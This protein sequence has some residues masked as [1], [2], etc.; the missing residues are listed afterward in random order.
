VVSADKADG[1]GNETRLY[2][3]L[4]MSIIYA[5]GNRNPTSE[6]N[7]Y[8]V[9][10]LENFSVENSSANFVP[11]FIHR[12]IIHPMGLR[13]SKRARFKFIHLIT[14][15]SCRSS[16]TDIAAPI[17]SSRGSALLPLSILS[18]MF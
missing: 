6:R 13:L 16:V 10:L 12:K 4:R 11:G 8:V 9:M 18:D 7:Y 14:A 5:Q 1:G 2:E 17:S 3:A 15:N